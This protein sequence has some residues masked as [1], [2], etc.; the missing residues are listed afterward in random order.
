[1]I[2]HWLYRLTGSSSLGRGAIR[3]T[4]IPDD[5]S[6][7]SHEILDCIACFLLGCGAALAQQPVTKP[8]EVSGKTA[9]QASA[10]QAAAVPAASKAH[11]TRSLSFDEKL[12]RRIAHFDM[13]GR[14]IFAS[15]L[16]LIYEYELPAGIANADRDSVARPV[17]LEFHHQSVRFAV[18]CA[19]HDDG[20]ARAASR[21]VSWVH[22]RSPY[23]CTTP[24]CTSSSMPSSPKTE[25]LSGP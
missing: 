22:A 5:T 25:R 8:E 15:V 24:R 19:S 1:M 12:E 13:A 9:H 18:F 10:H 11:P 4:I 2:W 23:T 17:N 16:D 20:V 6:D 3:N 7:I 14:T 21:A